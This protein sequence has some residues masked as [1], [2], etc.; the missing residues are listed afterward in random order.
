M[1][2][3]KE[4]YNKVEVLVE[5]YI[6]ARFTTVQTDHNPRKGNCV[7]GNTRNMCRQDNYTLSFKSFC[8]TL[9][10][11]KD[12]LDNSRQILYTRSY[13]LLTFLYKGLPNMPID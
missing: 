2:K 4:C 11:N 5:R 10:Y 13:A 6:L 3:F 9:R 8:G 7:I 1:T 12:I